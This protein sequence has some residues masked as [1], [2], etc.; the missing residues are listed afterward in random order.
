MSILI[1]ILVSL[2]YAAF[3]IHDKAVLQGIA[4]EI[5]VMGSNLNQDQEKE[6]KMKTLRDYLAEG[7]LLGTERR[8]VELSSGEDQISVTCSGSFPVPGLIMRFFSGGELKIKMSWKREL[9]HPADIIRKIRG[10][11]YMVDAIKE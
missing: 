8:K 9:Y 1:P 2:I 4:C 10:A 11:K 3:F 6:S 5:A 7:R